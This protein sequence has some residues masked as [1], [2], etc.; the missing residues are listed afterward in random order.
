MQRIKPQL[1]HLMISDFR[2]KATESNRKPRDMRIAIPF[3][4]CGIRLLFMAVGLGCIV[5]AHAELQNVQVGTGLRIRNLDTAPA[6][7]E[8]VS[9]LRD[10]TDVA[11]TVYN[12]NLA[13]VRDTRR[14]PIAAG[15][16]LLRFEDVAALIRPETVNFSGGAGVQVLEQ[17]Y[18]YD[19]ITPSKLLEKYVGK[20]LRIHDFSSK[21][22]AGTVDAELLSVNEGQIYR[23]DGEIFIG[24][25]GHV[26]LPTLPENLAA[27]P[28]LIWQLASDQNVDSAVQVSYLTGGMSWSADY[29]LTLASD[30]K[31]LDIEGWVTLN[32]QSGATY[33]NAQLKVVAGEV[34]TVRDEMLSFDVAD[35][36]ATNGL[37][38][39]GVAMRQEAFGEYHLYTL[40][41][42]TTIKENQSKQVSLLSASGVGVSKQYEYR[43]NESFYSQR[44]SPITEDRIAA[45]L[46]FD[47]ETDNKLGI[48][49]PAGVMR[50]Y[51][52]D[53]SGML[54]F[55]G[56]DRIEHTPKDE[57]VRLRL[58][59][60]FDIVGERTQTDFRILAENLYESSF[61]I[62]IRNHKKTDIVVDV[63]EPMSGDWQILKKSLEF[64]K[65]DAQTAVFTVP[66]PADGE[67]VLTYLVRVSHGQPIGIPLPIR[68]GIAPEAPVATSPPPAG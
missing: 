11:V 12:N 61:T 56:E 33:T 39:G 51:Q 20:T 31:S 47:N 60:A 13:L 41:R 67:A 32:N 15:E 36:V 1:R 28:S 26:V 55:S 59:N 6:S 16:H 64:T 4:R 34:N 58:G 53:A 35:A 48:P 30:E 57:E 52:E 19:L 18:E 7:G 68:G 17:N 44:I 23:V 40:P 38:A 14:M 63:V 5:S 3:L 46:V 24:R 25:P 50:V 10:Q 65:K 66:V 9:T 54:Q 21:S 62:T 37:A 22:K 43:G 42:R 8:G 27:R 45:Y 29:V 2:D 49:L